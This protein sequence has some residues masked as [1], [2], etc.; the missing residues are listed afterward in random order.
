MEWPILR[1]I[2]LSIPDERLQ[3][4]EFLKAFD[5]ALDEDIQESIGLFDGNTM[6]GTCSLSGKVMKGFAVREDYRG[7]N[8]TSTLVSEMIRRL[9]LRGIYKSF[10]FTKPENREIFENVGYKYLAGG[11]KVIL[12][13]HGING[14]DDYIEV[15]KKHR[16][17]G[18]IN[19]CIVMN[20]NPFT[21]GHRY[22]IERS[23][24]MCEKL[25]IFVVREDRS[26]FPFHVRKKLIEYGT[27]DIKNV[28]IIDGGDYIISSATFPGYFIRKQNERIFS[29]ASLDIDLFTKYVAQ[30]LNIKKRFVGTEPYDPVTLTYNK[31]MAKNLPEHGIEFIEIPRFEVDGKA[32]SAS[33]V[34]EDI[35]KGDFEDLKK[36]LPQT[37]LDFLNTGEGKIIMEKIKN[38]SSP[39]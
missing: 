15:L 9:S 24:S 11:E 28:E 21:L 14:I 39:H 26:L 1:D 2:D 7:L 32:I 13:E 31:V 25:Y 34:R 8:L 16:S 12:L 18:T 33:R 19:G 30:V 4:E 6:V 23:S 5:L 36:L 22:L 37:T 29:E 27:S 20:C 10:I 17:E 38:S 3:L 35:R